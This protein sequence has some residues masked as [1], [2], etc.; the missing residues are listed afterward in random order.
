MNAV[1]G[2]IPARGGSKGI[3]RK[4]LCPVGGHPLIAWTICA[5]QRSRKLSACLV[6]TDSEEIAEVARWYGADV[7]FI[8]PS[9]LA[10]DT[11]PTIDVVGHAIRHYEHSTGSNI[12]LVVVLQP[13]TPFRTGED[14]DRAIAL[15]EADSTAQ[16]LISGYDASHAHPAIMHV[17]L[18]DRP[19]R[20]VPLIPSAAGVGR[21]QEFPRV[22]VRNGAVY[23]ARR[24]LV[25]HDRRLWDDAPLLYEMPRERSLNIDAP[26]DLQ[27]AQLLAASNVVSHECRSTSLPDLQR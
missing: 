27:L 1:L 11:S 13:T 7:P 18:T 23:V 3:P 5:A 2:I 14:I 25:L 15:M 26:Y 12:S 22:F 21:R 8:R 24:D 20:V 17:P 10:D 4:N 19:G 6:S 9:S 16:S